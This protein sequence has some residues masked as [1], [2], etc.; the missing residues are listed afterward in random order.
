MAQ[1][2]ELAGVIGTWVAV[3]LA[4]IALFGIIGPI[5]LVKRAHSERNT[6]LNS[7]DDKDHEFVRAWWL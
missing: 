1:S 4:L 5:L 7:V 3:S 6:A 2:T